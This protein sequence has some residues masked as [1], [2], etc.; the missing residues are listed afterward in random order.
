[1]Y[2]LAIKNP[3][4][5]I[6]DL[7]PSSRFTVTS[8]SGLTPPKAN[9]NLTSGAFMDG[10]VFNS[11]AAKNRNIVI[12][13]AV[14]SPAEANRLK[15]YEAAPIKKPCTV[16]ITTGSRAVSILGY[17][18][19]C[20]VEPF[21]LKTMAQLSIICPAPWFV[22]TAQTVN[23]S[24]TAAGFTNAGDIPS[25]ADFTLNIGANI[26]AAGVE[27]Q[28]GDYFEVNYSFLSGDVVTIT[29]ERGAKTVILKRGNTYTN[30]INYIAT[31]STWLQIDGGAN[32]LKTDANITGTAVF[33]P[34][35][36]GV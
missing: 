34:L 1:M 35:F 30:L 23:L 28:N 6:T 26:S 3:A 29:T 9:I 22:G 12:N 36:S 13:M 10:S 17:V 5:V 31:G 25:G 18:E 27:N 19:A 8:V 7:V 24:A 14:E 2:K 33:S 11:A 32:S 4:G 20:E 15:L 21:K 16:Y